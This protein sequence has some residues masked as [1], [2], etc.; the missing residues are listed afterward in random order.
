MENKNKD[1]I[2]RKE[3]S[4]KWAD[5]PL[6]TRVKKE[7]TKPKLENGWGQKQKKNKGTKF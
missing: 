2:R 3:P 7:M 6:L 5:N 1:I 4:I